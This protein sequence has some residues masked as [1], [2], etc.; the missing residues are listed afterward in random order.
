MSSNIF[1]SL[2]EIVKGVE[3]DLVIANTDDHI[4]IFF[5]KADLVIGKLPHATVLTIDNGDIR[6]KQSMSAMVLEN[7]THGNQLRHICHVDIPQAKAIDLKTADHT[8][9]QFSVS[10]LAVSFSHQVESF[11]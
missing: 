7:G 1:Y 5:Y 9:G 3:D 10:H 6:K 8:S 4:V 11:L 2:P